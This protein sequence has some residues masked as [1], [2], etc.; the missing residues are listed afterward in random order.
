M[1]G[2]AESSQQKAEA[3]NVND[4]LSEV[5]ELH[6]VILCIVLHKLGPWLA[7]ICYKPKRPF[8]PLRLDLVATTQV[9]H[10]CRTLVCI[11]NCENAS[12]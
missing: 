10:G 5:G 2:Q 6:S 3:D 9:R 8:G 4:I 12:V 11:V 1:F 7:I